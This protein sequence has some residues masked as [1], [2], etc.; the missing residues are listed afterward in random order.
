[1]EITQEPEE[2]DDVNEPEMKD[3]AKEL[4]ERVNGGTTNLEVEDPI[5]KRPRIA[6]VDDSKFEKQPLTDV[7]GSAEAKSAVQESNESENPL[8]STEKVR[9]VE[10]T[11]QISGYQV[12]VDDSSEA[13]EKHESPAQLEDVVEDS[14]MQQSNKLESSAMT[15]SSVEIPSGGDD[16]C[17]QQDTGM[18]I[19]D[20]VNNADP[21]APVVKESEVEAAQSIGLDTENDKNTVSNSSLE[22]V[23]SGQISDVPP[24]TEEGEISVDM[25]EE[26]DI[27]DEDKREIHSEGLTQEL[28]FPS[29]EIAEFPDQQDADLDQ[30]SLQNPV[31]VSYAAASGQSSQEVPTINNSDTA[32]DQHVLQVPAVN[33]SDVVTIE[34]K[35]K[36]DM[37]VS[38]SESVE[39]TA[40]PATRNTTINLADRARERG[41]I[42]ERE[43]RVDMPSPSV[44]RGRGRI[45]R[46]TKR[47]GGSARGRGSTADDSQGK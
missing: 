6:R 47:G 14:K 23:E 26:G 7:K 36:G 35:C 27:E 32:L 29:E 42:R 44:S 34:D 25:V 40:R 19:V 4:S 21:S 45:G 28:G 20:S 39:E 3:G 24:D 31:N 33:V 10:E 12:A 22:A 38:S 30:T 11:I 9:E 18:L 46:G 43:R 13:L 37:I 8:V 2:R 41:R 16:I 15:F 17:K 5:S 1:M